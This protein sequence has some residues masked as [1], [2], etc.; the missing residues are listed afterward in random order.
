MSFKAEFEVN[1]KKYRV[2]HC[3]YTMSQDTDKTG[4]PSSAVR[5]GTLQLE[6]ESTGDSALTEWAF[7][8]FKEQDG[9][10]TFTQRNSD[11]KM[12]ELTFKNGYIVNYSE[13]FANQG[14]NPMTEH[15]TITSKDIKIGNAEYKNDWPV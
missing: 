2:L 4:R 9:K 3:S 15:F 6:V 1:G 8:A 12:K 13:A 11:Q 14:E 5:A 7:D 10:V